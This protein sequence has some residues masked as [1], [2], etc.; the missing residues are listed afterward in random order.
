MRVGQIAIDVTPL[1]EGRDFRLLFSGRFVVF[2]GDA[3]A[4][5]AANWRCSF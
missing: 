2:A 5:T 4:T 3:I 1:R